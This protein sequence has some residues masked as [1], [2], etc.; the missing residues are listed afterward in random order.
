VGVSDGDAFSAHRRHGPQDSRYSASFRTFRSYDKDSRVPS[1][2]IFH[3][4]LCRISKES[5]V[6]RVPVE[7]WV[8]E[9][10]SSSIVVDVLSR[11]T[12]FRRIIFCRGIIVRDDDGGLAAGMGNKIEEIDFRR[13]GRRRIPPARLP[14]F[15]SAT[16]SSSITPT[17]SVELI[18]E[19]LIII[20]SQIERWNTTSMQKNDET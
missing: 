19:S 11:D 7:R 12:E 20:P 10:G 1:V 6:L 2:C 15:I 8:V 9:E 18:I 5:R 13:A 4:K 17:G 14:P 3:N 16:S